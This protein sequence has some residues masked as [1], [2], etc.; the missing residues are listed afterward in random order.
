MVISN[1]DKIFHPKSIALVGAS[2]EKD[3]VGYILM[4]NLTK[5]ATPEKYILSIF[6][7]LRFLD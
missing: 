7:N 2:D 3:S 1:L 4:E 5:A 6:I